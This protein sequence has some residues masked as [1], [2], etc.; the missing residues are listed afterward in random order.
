M[1]PK[2]DAK[3]KRWNLAVTRDGKEVVV[4]PSHI[5]IATS[6]LGSPR[7]PIVKDESLFTGSAFHACR[8]HGGEPYQG[9]RVLIVG[10]GNTGADIAQDCVTHGAQAVTIL[11]RSST[12]TIS[13]QSVMEAMDIIFPED[14][15]T[16]VSD[17]KYQAYPIGLQR[18]WGIEDRE[19]REKKDEDLF[20]KLVNKGVKLNQGIDGS[21]QHLL[22]YERW[23]GASSVY[24]YLIILFN[25]ALLQVSVRLR[26][27]APNHC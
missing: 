8:F 23:G 3:Y 24:W 22:I 6:T 20:R 15:D 16:E 13:E 1:K 19:K 17:F 9:K 21:G 12:C 27:L 4:H 25:N 14:E 2:Y 7:I 26:Y 5:V 10:A 11:Q 18:Q